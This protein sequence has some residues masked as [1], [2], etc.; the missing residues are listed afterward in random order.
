MSSFMSSLSL[1]SKCLHPFPQE[2]S[3][4]APVT[5]HQRSLSFQQMENCRG[6]QLNTLRDQWTVGNPAPVGIPPSQPP[7]P[8]LRE[9]CGRRTWR[10]WREGSWERL[11]GER[12]EGSDVILFQLK[13]YFLKKRKSQQFNLWRGQRR[14]TN[15]CLAES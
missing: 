11:E 3:Q 7:N 10:G 4:G 15:L 5:F 9:H 13:T 12:M 8:R 1:P 2:E 6:P 14:T